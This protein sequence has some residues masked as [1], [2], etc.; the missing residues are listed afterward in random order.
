MIQWLPGDIGYI[1]HER[2]AQFKGEGA[3]W[4]SI[5]SFH[6]GTA[7]YQI[8]RGYHAIDDKGY[9]VL[10]HGQHYTISIDSETTVES[11]CLF[12]APWFV[13]AT[14]AHLLTPL[15]RH[16]DGSQQHSDRSTFF[17]QRAFAHDAL[18]S[19]T[20]ARLRGALTSGHAPAAWL[21]EQFHTVVGQLLQLNAVVSAEVDLLPLAR[22]ATREEVYRRLYQAKDYA[23]AL[24]TTPI[25][26]HDLAHVAALSP[27]H[28]LRSFKMVFGQT[29]YQ[30][31]TARR[32]H[33]AQHLLRTTTYSVSEICFALGFH[34]LGTFS[35]SFRQRVGVSPQQYRRLSR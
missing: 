8:G 20:L 35:W 28:L 23:D 14:Q 22:R 33:H 34:S 27:N 19:P 1:L 24:F 13:Q 17:F 29:P 21:A 32:I 4:L 5:K 26:L 10:N 2:A 18:V 11:L 25:S 30:Y 6:N 16:L 7:R 31:I 15:D 3:G 12:F 9:F